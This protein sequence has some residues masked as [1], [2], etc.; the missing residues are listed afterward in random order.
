MQKTPKISLSLTVALVFVLGLL[1][2]ALPRWLQ[3]QGESVNAAVQ[4][5]IVDT[6]SC[7]LNRQACTAR[8]PDGE[9]LTLSL[10]PRPVPLVKTLHSEVTLSAGL[11]A[12]VKRT[13]LQLDFNGTEMDMGINRSL[14][15]APHAGDDARF[16]GKGMLPI[17]VTGSMRWQ[18][19]V[20]VPATTGP[21]R[22]I[23]RFATGH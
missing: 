7:D 11:A 17:C 20:Q 9:T 15:E 14:L 1:V 4:T 3:G 8:W 12:A 10:A 13:P 16:E 21:R 5:V 2:F 18:A 23:F 19:E 22:A 6:A